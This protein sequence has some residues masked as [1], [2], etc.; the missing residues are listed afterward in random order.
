VRVSRHI[1]R[2]QTWYLLQD[3]SS[4]RHHR[5]DETAFHFIGRMDGAR[6]VDEIWHSMFNSLGEKSPTQ[7][8]TIEMLCQLSENGLLQCE[9]TPD[10]AELFRRGRQRARKRRISMLNPLAFR[11][12]LM[13]P[14]RLLTSLAPLARFLFN[15]VI[16]LLWAAVVVATLLSALSSWESI[17]SFAAIH[18]LTPRYLMLMWMV[19]PFV[20]ALHELGHGL[21]V[22]AWGGEVREAGVS[23]LLLVPAPFVDASAASAFPEKYR[24]IAVGAAGIMV[25][26]FL[27]AIA[28]YIWSR[29]SDGIV[30][31]IAFVIMVIGGVST[32]LFNGNP[33]LRFDG[34]YILS[35]LIDIPNLGQRSNA[36]LAYFAQRYLLGVATVTSP[37]TGRGEGLIFFAY[38]LLAFGYRWVVT[39]LIVMWAGHI[40]FWLGIAIAATVLYSMV[41]QP[42]ARLV[43]F[44]K[45]APQL[46]RNRSRGIM[47]TGTA[48]IALLLVFCFV[49]M[50]FITQ[51]KGVVW[52]PEQAR[53]RAATE[54]FITEVL[55]KDGQEVN[56]GDPI[57]VL[58]DPDLL[59][60]RETV[61]AAI[62]A[63]DIQYTREIGINTARA[64]SIG[65]EAAAKRDELAQLDQRVDHLRVVSTERGALV[66]PR[67]QDLPGTFVSKG[68]VL[69]H[70]LRAEQIR[71]KVAVWQ[72]DS[73]LIRGGA[74]DVEVRLV[75][76]PDQVLTGRLTG[77]VPAATVYLPTAAL[78]DRAGGP[79]VTDPSDKEGTKTLEPMFLYEL[80]LNTKTLERVGARVS[81]R[82]D[83][84][85]KPL[86]F[87]VQRRLQQ[88]FLKQF[89]PQT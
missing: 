47:I 82:F 33:L 32:V 88:L 37:V 39:A 36:Y 31:D 40:S 26:L 9:I 57:L 38:A 2:G 13:D 35:D 22:K 27:A 64:K 18:M 87:Q 43:L 49:P 28:W 53:I 62:Q 6:T 75:D 56:V 3:A 59:A 10:V 16:A 89:N 73:G 44:L 52:L 34:Y 77:E 86:A 60:E 84:G 58:S 1:Y 21:A 24:R 66:M 17:R 19:Y 55:A 74:R 78:G 12:P 29:V 4:G 25:E 85:A 23:M 5:V 63:L 30:R 69:A 71:I 8:D 48:A 68:T 72:E 79:I 70:V 67:A 80:L 83:H 7:D 11:V 76:A 81:V 20:K 41:M 51:A 54:G 65:E 15:P 50:P 42:L 45:R 14:D 61:R 46:A